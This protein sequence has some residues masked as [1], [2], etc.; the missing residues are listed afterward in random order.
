M[1][2][3]MFNPHVPLHLNSPELNFSHIQWTSIKLLPLGM[4]SCLTIKYFSKDPLPSP[5]PRAP[6]TSTFLQTQ[7]QKRQGHFLP[8]VSIKVQE[9]D[10]TCGA[11][12]P[13][14]ESSQEMPHESSPTRPPGNRHVWKWL[15]S[16]HW[17]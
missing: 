16:A 7:C 8:G 15:S 10:L 14:K 6:F 12:M 1:L 5:P 2:V 9:V 3:I 4:T 11:N 17:H 13:F